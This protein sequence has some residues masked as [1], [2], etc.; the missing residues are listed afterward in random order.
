VELFFSRRIGIG[1]KNEAIT[2]L[3]GGRVSGKAG[4]FNVGLLNMQTDDYKD[5]LPGDNFTVIR[6]SRDLPNRSSLGGLFI[7]RQQTGDIAVDGYHNRT[8]S[9]DG[10]LGVGDATVVSGFLARTDTPGV[11]EDDY[12]FN[13]R[14]RTNVPRFDFEAGYQEVAERFNPE[15][16]FLTRRGY[17]KPDVRLLTRWR[18]QDFMNI[19][20]LRPHTSYRA[21]V[22]FD[23]FLE[24]GYWHIDNHWVFNNSYEVH[25][26]VNLT[27][28]GVRVPFEIYP[29]IFVPP[30]SYE[31]AEVQL[32]FMTNQ[33]SPVSL[34]VQSIIGGFFG[35]DRVSVSPTLRMRVG[36]A[37]TTE[38]AYQV[39]DVDLPWGT[40]TT[41]LMRT[42][43]SYSFNTHTFVQ[44]LVQYNDRADLWSMNVRFGWLQAA[45]TGLFVVY[46]DT[47]GLYELVPGPIRTDRSFVVK[48]S[49]MFDLLR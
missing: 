48:Y 46:T 19:Q 7:N 5:V 40:F 26:G 22:G 27:E 33:S 41:N 47:R 17:R 38:V 15:V 42:R 14:S 12:A 25:T 43:V 21:F 32:V 49:R 13:V 4:K 31:E 44:G 8:Y 37:L 23:G 2:I 16:G 39:N 28:E 9:V 11:D 6:L 29:R 30:G 34:N 10:K 36:D 3:G 20:E 1:P 24:S 45:N 18:P 35:G